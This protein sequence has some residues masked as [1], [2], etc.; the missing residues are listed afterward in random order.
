MLTCSHSRAW[1]DA[2]D[3]HRGPPDQD[4]DRADPA[5]RRQRRVG[6]PTAQPDVRAPTPPRPPR[7]RPGRCRPRSCTARAGR[8]PAAGTPRATRLVGPGVEQRRA[9]QHAD[10]PPRCRRRT[11]APAR[12]YGPSSS[13]SVSRTLRTGPTSA[14]AGWRRP[15]PAGSGRP[16]PARRSTTSADSSPIVGRAVA[17]SS[18]FTTTTGCVGSRRRPVSGL[19][20]GFGSGFGVGV[21]DGVGRPASGSASGSPSSSSGPRPGARPAEQP[22]SSDQREHPSR[23]AAR[24]PRRRATLAADVRYPV[25]RPA[26][27]V[28][29]ISKN[30]GSGSAPARR[31]SRGIR[32]RRS[33]PVSRTAS[34][35]N[36]GPAPPGGRQ[37]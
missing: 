27:A 19:T 30:T 29:S 23:T 33:D 14:G 8:H 22:A 5:C 32:R 34:L 7:Q 11:P 36:G 24:S 6:A 13:G 2:A 16:R 18:I 35:W 12:P 1:D 20:A 28:S 9:A 26:S 3:A 4:D 10:R 37:S 17:V 15:R 25:G 31:S 21:G